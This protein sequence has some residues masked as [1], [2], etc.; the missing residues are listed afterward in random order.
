MEMFILSSKSKEEFI[1]KLY[2]ATN[3]KITKNKIAIVIDGPT[4][5]HVLAD[6]ILAK[7]FFQFGYRANSVICCRVSPK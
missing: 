3:K 4:L 7:H 2:E 5:T 1:R 6:D